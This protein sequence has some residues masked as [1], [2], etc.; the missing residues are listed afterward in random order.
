MKEREMKA[1]TYYGI[2]TMARKLIRGVAEATVTEEKK[3]NMRS[4][5]LEHYFGSEET[6]KT[7]RRK[8]PR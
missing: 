8:T 4:V 7:T 1:K 2:K 3:V 5:T 6:Q